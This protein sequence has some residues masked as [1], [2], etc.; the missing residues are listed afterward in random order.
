MWHASI[1][2]FEKT[3]R[4]I[5]PSRS[6]RTSDNFRIPMNWGPHKGDFLFADLLTEFRVAKASFSL[7]G[8]RA[9]IKATMSPLDF[10][11]LFERVRALEKDLS[12]WETS[13]Y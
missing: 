7:D 8:E 9:I 5:D 1:A 11:R 12:G 10:S 6:I 13:G 4:K 3:G 2:I